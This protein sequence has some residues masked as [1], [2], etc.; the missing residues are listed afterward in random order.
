MR[1]EKILK[2]ALIIAAIG[3]LLFAGMKWLGNKAN[4]DLSGYDG[5]R[6]NYESSVNDI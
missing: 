3:L 4:D 6:G 1:L 5:G 2:P